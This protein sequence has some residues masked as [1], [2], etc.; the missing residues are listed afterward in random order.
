MTSPTGLITVLV[1]DRNSGPY[2]ADHQRMGQ[3]DHG[4]GGWGGVGGVVVGGMWRGGG[5]GGGGGWG[6]GGGWVGVPGAP[7]PR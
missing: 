4:G 2:T 5:G 7:G 3:K 6:A 1:P